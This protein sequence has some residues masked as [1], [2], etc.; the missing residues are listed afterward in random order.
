MKNKLVFLIIWLCSYLLLNGC[1][2]TKYE[3]PPSE[4]AVN[5]AVGRNSKVLAKKYCMR[6]FAITVAMPGGDIKYLELEFQIRGPLSINEMR[7]ILINSAHDFLIDINA[8]LELCSYLNN[9]QMGIKDIGIKIFLIDSAGIDLNEPHISIA[10]IKKGELE[11]KVTALKYDKVI[12]I[13]IPYITSVSTE[14]Y[15]EAIN[16]LKSQSL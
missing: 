4:K 16:A 3:V 15:E 6:P 10:S 11:Y 9:N 8:D 14:T 13:D 12:K 5:R 7:K 1:E 2:S